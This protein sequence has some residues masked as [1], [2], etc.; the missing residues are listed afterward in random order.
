M[1]RCRGPPACGVRVAAGS[2]PCAAGLAPLPT[3]RSRRAVRL[4][5][6]RCRSARR[7]AAPAV[8]AVP[9]VPAEC[10]A[11]VPAEAAADAWRC[12]A[13]GVCAA[14]TRERRPVVAHASPKMIALERPQSNRATWVRSRKIP[15]RPETLRRVT[16]ISFQTRS[17]ARATKLSWAIPS[18]TCRSG[19]ALPSKGI[20]RNNFRYAGVAVVRLLGS[21]RLADHVV[22]P[23]DGAHWQHDGNGTRCQ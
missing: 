8:S 14:V 23:A 18:A 5:R 22:R 1:S 15:V 10:P 6:R 21:V 19:A 16:S 3:A 9:G 11:A 12:A 17:V 20:A 13:R 2:R 7:R 4:P